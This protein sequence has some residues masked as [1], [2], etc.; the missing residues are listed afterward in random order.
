MIITKTGNPQ[1][2]P[3]ARTA[4]RYGSSCKVGDVDSIDRLTPVAIKETAKEEAFA[5]I[6]QGYV[7]A[8]KMLECPHCSA[9]FFLLLDPRDRV[10]PEYS[11]A[12]KRAADYFRT[13]IA[14][15][16]LISHPLNRLL[17]PR[18]IRQN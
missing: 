10:A 12:E 3:A 13:M 11:E 18:H 5:L 14:A 9:R 8:R 4:L 1:S 16:H 15:Q 7:Q 6:R 17:M 2:R